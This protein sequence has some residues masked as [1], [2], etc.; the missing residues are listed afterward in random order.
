MTDKEQRE[1]PIIA[2]IR[3]IR[4]EHAKRFNYDIEAILMDLR[5]FEKTLNLEPQLLSKPILKDTGS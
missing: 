5:L 3:A 1:D 4:D 2:E